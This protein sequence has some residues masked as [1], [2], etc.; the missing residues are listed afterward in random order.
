M[1]SIMQALVSVP[2]FNYYF[3]KRQYVDSQDPKKRSLHGAVHKFIKQTIDDNGREQDIKE[4]ASF[5]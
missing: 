4:F 2:Q 5:F 3:F 1:I